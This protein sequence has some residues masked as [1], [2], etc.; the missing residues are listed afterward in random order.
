M[1]HL[2]G[3]VLHAGGEATD[4]W[5][6]GGIITYRE[7]RGGSRARTIRGFA[8]PGLVDVHCH[9]GLGSD[10]VV[11]R[12]EALAQASDVLAT[13]VTLVRDLGVP[14]DMTWIDSEPNTPH[15]IHC[16]T[17]IAR[18]KRY[19]R[20]VS[21]D[22]DPAE[23]PDVVVEEAER[24]NG[25]VK[26]VGDWIERSKGSDADL[27]PLWPRDILIDAVQ[28]AHEAGAKVAVHTFATETIDDLLDAGVDDIE[29]G[30]GMT[31]DHMQ[32]AAARG[33]LVTPT[34][35][36]V[37]SFADIANQAGAKYPVYASRMKRMYENRFDHMAA[38]ADAG[39]S[40]LMGSDSGST[41][42]HG[43]FPSELQACVE[44][45]IPASTVIAAASWEGRR[46]LGFP[47]LEE[48]TIADV[49]VY[50]ADPRSDMGVVSSPLAVIRAGELV[51]EAT[52]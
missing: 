38:M 42:A 9:I 43:T 16:G 25:W 50:S 52:D 13:G 47:A 1:I 49:V 4:A 31:L 21:R 19:L 5:I 45:G 27:E 28:A 6:D 44:A 36:Q 18:P 29:H 46:R 51:S 2:T 30:T 39:I 7:P 24:G 20:G 33:I 40:L 14:A 23:L 32:D 41:L 8:M 10:I 48:G 22:I 35:N 15:I 17:H 26:L 11:D 12:D 3:T 34:A 37:A